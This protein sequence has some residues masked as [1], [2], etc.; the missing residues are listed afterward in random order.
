MDKVVKIMSKNTKKVMLLI[1]FGVVLFVGLQNFSLVLSF[2]GWILNLIWPFLLGF[3]V[4]FILNV[5]MSFLESKIFRGPG[6]PKGLKQ[7]LR[8]PVSL[9]LTLLLV[10]GVI[11]IVMFL[12]VP[13]LGRTFQSLVN[14]IPPFLEN[15]QKWSNDMFQQYPDVINWLQN[16]E[17]DWQ[18]IV[19][20]LQNSAG[21]V[22]SST[23]T[24]ASSV[25]GGIVNFFLGIIFAFYVLVQKEKLGRQ[26]R[27][28]LYACLPERKAEKVLSVCS[29][30][31]KTFASFLSGQCLEAVILGM[32]FFISMS[33]FQ[34]PY[35][36]IISVL[37]AFMA[38]IPIFG[39]II[40]CVIGAFLILM[41]DP[42]RAI[43]FVVLFLVI[44]QIEGNL[45]YP[46]VVGN[47]V[48]LPSMWVLV[49]VTLGGSLMGFAG[50]LICI[51]LCSVVY[52][53]ASRA[54]NKRL[55]KKAARKKQ[56]EMLEEL[57]RP[58]DELDDSE[59]PV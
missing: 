4:A 53:L 2:V 9:L 41:I 16:I 43:W 14:A 18:S 17:L 36:L 21:D 3:C 8:R 47:S 57:S 13:E 1:A 44:Q 32:L 38:L 56:D 49:A 10:A 23:V 45:I 7:R 51:P 50:M 29:L 52:T 59:K 42:I 19:Q 35:A 58:D 5:P 54:I 25:V 22:L 55:S 20:M 12:I 15:L 46:H 24:V 26:G 39:A 34:F 37:I 48:G 27:K 11:F 40:G 31:Y 28:L 6:K 30:S 33:I